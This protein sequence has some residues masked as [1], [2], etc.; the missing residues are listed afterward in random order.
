MPSRRFMRR[1][2]R[3]MRPKFRSLR[4]RRG[5]KGGEQSGIATGGRRRGVDIRRFAT[6]PRLRERRL[7]NPTGGIMRLS[8]KLMLTLIAATALIAAAPAS[9][10]T[11]LKWAHVYETSEPYHKWSVWAAQEIEKRTDGRYHIDVFPA[12]SLG[13]ES[14]LNQGLTLGTVDM[15]ISGLSFAARTTPRIG[16][17]YYPYTFRDGDHLIAWAKSPAFAEMTDE[18]RNKTGIQITAM[19]YYGVRQSTSNKD[20]NDCAGMK[21]IKMRVPDV[22]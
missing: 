2:T 14:D 5:P 6:R 19:T 13:K 10:Q 11:K 9:A 12:S 17:G 21:G 16:V 4:E 3:T 1:L 18:Y 8:S 22:P 15:I 20:F 7:L